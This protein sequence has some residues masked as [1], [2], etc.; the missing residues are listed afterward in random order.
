[1]RKIL[2]AHFVPRVCVTLCPLPARIGLP[3]VPVQ[4]S[5]QDSEIELAHKRLLL[6]S[7]DE[8]RAEE[9]IEQLRWKFLRF[10]GPAR[11]P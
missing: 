4:A 9:H 6:S 11:L 8:H 1:M 3:N 2:S 5:I 7:A 10:C